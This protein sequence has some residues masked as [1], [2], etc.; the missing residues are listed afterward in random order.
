MTYPVTTEASDHPGG[1]E[2]ALSEF[3]D[4]LGGDARRPPRRRPR[5]RQCCARATRMFYGSYIYLHERL[6]PRYPHRSS[7]RA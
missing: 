1:Y 4:R 2:G 5:R 6:A 7:C 3:Y